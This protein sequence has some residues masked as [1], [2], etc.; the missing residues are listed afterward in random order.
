MSKKR[1]FTPLEIKN[2]NGVSSIRNQRSY[3]VSKR[4]LT[5]PV[6]KSSSNGAGFTLVEL[7]FVI[8]IIALLMSILMPAL[9]RVRKQAKDVLCQVQLKQW[10]IIFSMYTDDNNGYFNSGR[11]GAPTIRPDWNQY[12]HRGDWI[13]ATRP[14]FEEEARK[15]EVRLCPMATKQKPGQG[16]AGSPFTS[17]RWGGDYGWDYGSYGLNGWVVNP[18]TGVEY[19]WGNPTKNNWRSARVKGAGIIPV[20]A[21]CGWVGGSPTPFDEP[22]V[23]Y[24]P[25]GGGTSEMKYFCINRH[26]GMINILFMDWS[27]RKIGLK[28]LWTLKWH[29]GYNTCGPW[30]KCGNV[31]PG[32]WPD[33]MRNF[34]DY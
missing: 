27:V 20:F 21:D 11:A 16:I 4:F 19:I 24:S 1:G 26:N 17:W 33:W 18:P 12:W 14:Y 32:E 7:L 10:G 15:V 2:S 13:M 34:R 28:Q 30:T 8:A 31:T 6:R 25:S 29:R 9:G 23:V 5:G 22:Q 3:G